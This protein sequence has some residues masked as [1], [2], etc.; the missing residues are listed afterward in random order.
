MSRYETHSYKSSLTEKYAMD[1]MTGL[2]LKRDPVDRDRAE[3]RAKRPGA[4]L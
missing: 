4:I 1:E 2:S 3:D